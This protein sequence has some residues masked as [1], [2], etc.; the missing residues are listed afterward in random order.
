MVNF[1]GWGR[2]L[3]FVLTGALAGLWA[4]TASAGTVNYNTTGSTLSCNGVAG[5]VQ[6]TTTSVTIGGLTFTYNTG[7]GSGVVTPS[8]INLGNIVSTGTS[9]GVNVT[10]LLLTINV[11]STPPGA[12]GTLPNG[13]VSG[14]I[15]T[16]NSGA[17]ITFSPNN[18]TTGFGTLPGVVI[19]GGSQAFIYQVLNPTLGLQ[20]PTVGNPIGQ[21][22][23]QGA[24]TDSSNTM[25]ANA[26]TTPQST[27]VSTAFANA[28]AVT[29]KNGS[30][31]GVP[32]INVTFT[33]PGTGASGAF[34]NSTNTIVVA[35]NASGVA[36]A[37]FTANATVG[38]PY[39][40]TAT[41]SGVANVTFSLTNTAGNPTSAT[42]NAGTT[43][44]SATV[45]TAFGTALAVTVMDSGSNPVSG[46][47]V[48]FTAPGSGASATFSNLT[49]T[50][51]VPT[52]A[53]GV[54]SAPVSANATAGS[55]NV[56]ATV[57]TLPPVNFA[58][59]NLSQSANS[60]P[61]LDWAGVLGFVLLLGAAGAFV[62]RT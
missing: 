10:G 58:L 21:T 17:T 18:T 24:V 44:Q 7:S 47:N 26:G 52:N 15:S 46:A 35:T 14:S 3:S 50:I 33:A 45:G 55:Y 37:P 28:L 41:A 34:S 29:V 31:V 56:T 53:S 40:V 4:V 27:A 49:N 9:A 23:I 39:T 11:N 43:P 61:A 42:A 54:A 32:G 8:I 38:G 22:S 16:N 19:S 48:V 6:N 57:S 1:R 60:V 51:T 2:V 59:T 62:L 25:T 5:C 12:S 30:N 36:S 20:A 13:A